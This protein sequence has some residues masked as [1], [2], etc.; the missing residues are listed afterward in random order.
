MKRLR[1][2]PV[3][4]EIES[5]VRSSIEVQPFDAV[6]ANAPNQLKK[7]VKAL[8]ETKVNGSAEL[9]K[10]V[11]ALISKFTMTK[12][13]NDETVL[14]K[15]NSIVPNRIYDLPLSQQQIIILQEATIETQIDCRLFVNSCLLNL[16]HWR[17]NRIPSKIN[18]CIH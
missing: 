8:L 15:I 3:E 16:N 12:I 13:Q 1:G 18:V 11:L 5:A 6:N 9:Q 10:A 4:E 7:T 2:E 14:D 17:I